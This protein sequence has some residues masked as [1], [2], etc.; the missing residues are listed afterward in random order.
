[1]PTIISRR[2]VGHYECDID[3]Y[4]TSAKT[5][6]GRNRRSGRHTGSSSPSLFAATEVTEV[7]IVQASI[8]C[9]ATSFNC[10]LAFLA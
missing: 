5:I 4:Y 3:H 1:M 6:T 2:R 7:I 8:I 9:R 10:G